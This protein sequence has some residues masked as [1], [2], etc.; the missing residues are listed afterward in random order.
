MATLRGVVT[1]VGEHHVSTH[2]QSSR[3]VDGIMATPTWKLLRA[4]IQ[5]RLQDADKD[6]AKLLDELKMCFKSLDVMQH[7][8]R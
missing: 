5:R 8:P 3:Y 1:R 7:T 6:L 4:T 2:E